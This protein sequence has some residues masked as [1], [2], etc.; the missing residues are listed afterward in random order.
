MDRTYKR[1]I[2]STGKKVLGDVTGKGHTKNVQG[3]GNKAL[4]RAALRELAEA[5]GLDTEVHPVDADRRGVDSAIAAGY[6]E[7]DSHQSIAGTTQLDSPE[8]LGKLAATMGRVQRDGG[9]NSPVPDKSGTPSLYAQERAQE[10]G[11][12]KQ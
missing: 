7:V 6:D 12:D 10:K 1:N 11:Q 3:K 8:S 4:K 9:Q 2:A 5:L